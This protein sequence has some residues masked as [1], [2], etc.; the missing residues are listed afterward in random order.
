MEHSPLLLDAYKQLLSENK[1]L[2]LLLQEQGIAFARTH[3]LVSLLDL[4]L[5]TDPSWDLI[6]PELASLTTSAVE[7]RYPGEIADRDDAK[8][9]ARVCKLARAR[10]RERLGL[11]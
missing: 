9:A 3:N 8:E 6:R 5:T 1:G 7:I 11:A 4:L 2:R 10:V